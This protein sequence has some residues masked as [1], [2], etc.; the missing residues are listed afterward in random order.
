[1]GNGIAYAPVINTNGIGG[2]AT[3]N[4]SNPLSPVLISDSDFT[5]T[6]GG[7]GTA[8]A[9]NGSGLGLLA[10]F[11]VIFANDTDQF[12]VLDVSDPQNTNNKLGLLH[13][14]GSAQSV[15]IAS[16]IA[17]VADGSAG[18]Q[19]VN[20]LPFDN[21]GVAPTV[22]ITTSAVDADPRSAGVQV[23][24]GATI[25]VRAGVTDDVEAR[26]VELLVNGVVVRNDVSF[27]FDFFAVAPVISPRRRRSRCKCGRPTP[28][29]T[30]ACRRCSLDDLVR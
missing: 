1:M 6:T 25:P 4:V 22:A 19:V 14:A 23:I 7:P 29:A 17:F 16:G 10:G 27:P 24:E 5:S 13:L 3:A 26:N 30:S 12:S 28:E 21:R 11:T 2:F 15:T 8:M 18:L 20:Y 9:V